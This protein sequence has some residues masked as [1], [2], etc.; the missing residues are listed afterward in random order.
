[1]S[2]PGSRS[3]SVGPCSA[4]AAQERRLVEYFEHAKLQRLWERR[5]VLALPEQHFNNDLHPRDEYFL[6]DPW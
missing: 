5:K 4:A 2:T 3:R 6:N 1:M